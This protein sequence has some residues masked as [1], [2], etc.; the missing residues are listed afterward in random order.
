KGIYPPINPL[1]S[2]SRLMDAG[3]GPGLTREDHKAVSDQMYAAYAEG[4]DARG[5]MAIVGKEALAERDRRLLEFADRFENEFIR[6]GPEEDRDIETTLEIGWELLA[7]LDEAW[8]TKIDRRTL[9]AYHPAHREKE[10]A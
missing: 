3:I 10:A 7:T 5:L 2:L 1:P 8:L 6:Q 9:D 4:R